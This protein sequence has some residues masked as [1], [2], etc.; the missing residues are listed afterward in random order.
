MPTILQERTERCLATPCRAALPFDKYLANV[1]V[2]SGKTQSGYGY[3]MKQFF[4][5][6]GNKALTS[7]KFYMDEGLDHVE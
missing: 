4:V 5:S 1:A 7:I 2:L 6:C 3:T